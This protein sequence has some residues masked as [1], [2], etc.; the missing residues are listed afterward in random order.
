MNFLLWEGFEYTW[1]PVTTPQ[2]V[3]GGA[4]SQ[5]IANN[6]EF[7]VIFKAPDGDMR[8]TTFQNA[9]VGLPFMFRVASRARHALHTR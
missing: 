2:E 1:P 3:V 5:P 7:D 8:K 9:D 4:L 6:G